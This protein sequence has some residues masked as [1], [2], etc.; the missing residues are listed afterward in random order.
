MGVLLQGY[1]TPASRPLKPPLVTSMHVTNIWPAGCLVFLRKC[2][3]PVS[4]S[5]PFAFPLSRRVFDLFALRVTTVSLTLLI[6]SEGSPGMGGPPILWIVR[7]GSCL[8]AFYPTAHR[9]S[10]RAGV[11]HTRRRGSCTRGG[12]VPWMWD[13][14]V[15]GRTSRGCGL[16]HLRGCPHGLAGRLT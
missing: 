12:G 13:C 3:Y 14:W 5:T 7:V 6:D 11:V 16:G 4:A 9:T 8:L 15:K 1:S 10:L 2:I